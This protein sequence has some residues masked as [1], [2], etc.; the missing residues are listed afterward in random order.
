MLNFSFDLVDL[1]YFDRML[2]FSF[3]LVDLTYFGRMT[4]AL[5]AGLER[6]LSDITESTVPGLCK[7]NVTIKIPIK[8]VI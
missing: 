1:T 3:D 5:E 2:N 4:V 7:H 6:T 8:D